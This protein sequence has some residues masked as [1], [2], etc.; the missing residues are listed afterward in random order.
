[1]NFNK[2]SKVSINLP[3]KEGKKKKRSTFK[4]SSLFLKRRTCRLDRGLSSGLLPSPTQGK[5]K[6]R[7]SVL[8]LIVGISSRRENR[9]RKSVCVCVYPPIPGAWS[10]RRRYN[11]KLCA[12]KHVT[13]SRL[14]GTCS[15][16]VRHPLLSFSLSFLLPEQGW[17]KMAKDRGNDVR[18]SPRS[19]SPVYLDLSD[20]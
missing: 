10:T 11:L 20:L 17:K 9:R 18:F 6:D 13:I 14:R 8:D 5:K 4:P 15:V 1:M 7:S 19:F 12:Q 2:N 16:Y 3:S